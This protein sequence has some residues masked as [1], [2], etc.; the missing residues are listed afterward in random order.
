MTGDV[1]RLDAERGLLEV[2]IEPAEL[3][4]R[5]AASDPGAGELGCGRELFA[6][7]RA[8]A[9]PAELGGGVFFRA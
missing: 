1:I 4:A 5:P 6:P 7:M 2:M 3:H 8:L 9:Q